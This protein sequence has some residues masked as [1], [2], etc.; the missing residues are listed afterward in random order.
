VDDEMLAEIARTGCVREAHVG[1]AAREG[2][3]PEGRVSV[4]RVRRLRE[5]GDGR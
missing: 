1:R 5:L 4:A 2:N 3:D